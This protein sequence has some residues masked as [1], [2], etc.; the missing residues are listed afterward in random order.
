M[1]K[2][3]QLEAMHEDRK[4]TELERHINERAETMTKQTKNQKEKCQVQQL[5][6]EC[7]C[8]DCMEY[9][10][11]LDDHLG[12]DWEH[13]QEGLRALLL[14]TGYSTQQIDNHL[15]IQND[16]GWPGGEVVPD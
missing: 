4:E 16:I 6:A 14:K 3:R 10:D 7:P 12:F 8:R 9:S 5:G 13:D 2:D 11:M 1:A 15:A